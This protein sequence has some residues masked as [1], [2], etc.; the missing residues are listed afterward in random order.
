MEYNA[1][2]DVSN[3]ELLSLFNSI[4]DRTIVEIETR[5]SKENISL[6]QSLKSLVSFGTEILNLEALETL[7][8]LCGIDLLK[9]KEEISTVKQFL[10]LKFVEKA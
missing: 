10:N 8:S 1:P 6:L 7:S 9:A 4:I 3:T 2:Q 5:F